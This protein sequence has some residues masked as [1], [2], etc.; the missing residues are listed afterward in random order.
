MPPLDAWLLN[1][2]AKRSGAG[3]GYSGVEDRQD[4]RRAHF[5]ACGA[6]ELPHSTGRRCVD[7]D[8]SV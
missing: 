2:A 8:S 6:A 4:L 3:V 5:H 7:T 1:P